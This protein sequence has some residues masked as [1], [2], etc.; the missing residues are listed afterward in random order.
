MTT[1]VSTQRTGARRK[2]RSWLFLTL[3]LGAA[4][5]TFVALAGTAREVEAAFPGQNGKIA[6]ES[7]R[8]GNAEIYVMNP[9]GSNPTNLTKNP[10]SDYEAAVSPDG[11]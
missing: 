9:N 1:E 10:A 11:K 8:E 2:R 4:L 6:F 5:S 7:I 3:A